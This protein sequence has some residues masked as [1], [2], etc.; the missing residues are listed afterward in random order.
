MKLGKKIVLFVVFGIG[1]ILFF[2][3]CSWFQ[4][5]EKGIETTLVYLLEQVESEVE[6]DAVPT[7]AE[8]NV[9]TVSEIAGIW[10]SNYVTIDNDYS[11]AFVFDIAANGEVAMGV[12]L[13]KAIKIDTLL[14]LGLTNYWITTDY[15]L[16][17]NVD[18]AE[19]KIGRAH[20]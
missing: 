14:V 13:N 18:D 20:V 16:S 9:A 15:S 8:N 7:N 10:Q 3:G 1:I 19:V 4:D 6:I 12:Y 11:V 2:T 5:V 17:T